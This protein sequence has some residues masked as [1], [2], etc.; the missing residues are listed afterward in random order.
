MKLKVVFFLL[1]AVYS[2]GQDNRICEGNL[3]ANIFDNGDFGFGNDNVVVMDPQ[4]APGYSY[5]RTVPPGDGFY[6][7]TNDMGQWAGLFQTWLPIGD[8]SGNRFGY[9]MVVNA[10]FEPGIFYEQTIDGLCDNTLYV[11]SADVINLIQRNVTNHIRP[12]VTFLLNDEVQYTTGEIAQ[13]ERWETHGFTFTTMPG[14]TTVKLTLR[15]NA[16]GGI[17]NDLAL[18]NIAFRACGPEALILPFEIANICEDGS[19]IDLDAT[20]NGD[21]FDTPA[22]QWQESLDAGM[23]WQDI[24]GANDFSF[25]HDKLSG[26]F[27]YYRYFVANSAVNL[28][29]T[30]CR[31][32]S[33][34]K[35]VHVVP[36]FYEI[37]DT[38]CQGTT[39]EVGTSVYST[40]G[41]YTDSL[42]SSIGCDSIVT[43]NLSIAPDLGIQPVLDIRPPSCFGYDDAAVNI[44]SVTNAYL[45]VSIDLEGSNGGP[46][47][48]FENLTSGDYFLSIVDRFNCRYEENLLIEDPPLFFIDIGE[49]T[50]VELGQQLRLAANT[51]YDIANFSWT[52]ADVVCNDDCL[53]LEWFPIQSTQY[54]IEATSTAGCTASDSIF[55]EVQKLRKA[56]I[57]NIFSPDGDGVNDFFTAFGNPDL[58]K[59][60]EKLMIFDRWGQQVFEKTNFLPNIPNEGWDGNSI[61]QPMATGVYVYLI[62]LRFLDDEVV[63]FSGDVLLLKAAR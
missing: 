8:N 63:N 58:V 17:G 18:D 50:I 7:V 25:T 14:Q 51:N 60:I 30:K 19:P 22:V 27:Y 43:L 57:P 47:P 23:T 32:I 2:Y 39:F 9:M 24:P 29:N 1:L 6:T 20:I 61:N 12:N 13:T 36:K 45:P 54:L 53:S 56:F 48:F 55:V 38:I 33:N 37:T 21:Q 11:F 62:Q 34:T 31:I 10:S 42:I 59:N 5:T 26:G 4:I 41:T 40:A 49:D 52:P 3:G 46:G 28:A 15:N 35:I 16:P 44:E